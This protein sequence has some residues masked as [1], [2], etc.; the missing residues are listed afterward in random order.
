MSSY[1]NL[2]SFCRENI[3]L[4]NYGKGGL[5]LYFSFYP[6]GT[7]AIFP[8]LLVFVLLEKTFNRQNFVPLSLCVCLSCGMACIMTT[9]LNK[10][11]LS[12]N[13]EIVRVFV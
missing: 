9:A 12:A 4:K 6:I 5:S 3:R 7:A 8:R 1:E 13:W 10:S 11:L 2:L